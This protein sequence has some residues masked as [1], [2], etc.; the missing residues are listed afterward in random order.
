[1]NPLLKLLIR[2]AIAFTVI[3]IAIQP[4]NWI[5]G[6]TQKCNSFHFSY[7]IPKK[8]GYDDFKFQFGVANYSAKSSFEAID[9]TLTTVINRKNT[10]HYRA[11]NLSK[12]TIYL[13]PKLLVT[14]KEFEPHIKIYDCLCSKV[15][16][17]KRGEEIELQMTFVINSSI[18]DLPLIEEYRNTD[19]VIG[20][21]YF[22]K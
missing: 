21:G 7:L 5:C 20:I 12:K 9:K 10:I 1:M 3:F 18:T 19:K 14:P 13:R 11:K 16:K 4:Y 22:V 8:E 2:F 6:L 17:L 15:Y